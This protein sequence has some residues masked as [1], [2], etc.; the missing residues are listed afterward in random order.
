MFGFDNQIIAHDSKYCPAFK[1]IVGV[2]D[3]PG[4]YGSAVGH[5]LASLQ[6]IQ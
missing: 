5:S 3:V 1:N 6:A 2:L 4:T